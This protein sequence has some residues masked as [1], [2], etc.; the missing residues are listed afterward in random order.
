MTPN[1]AHARVRAVHVADLRRTFSF[2]EAIAGGRRLRFPAVDTCAIPIEGLQR[3]GGAFLRQG[4]AAARPVSNP[5][6]IGQ[7]DVFANGF[8]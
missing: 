7:D 2:E 8:E 4:K 5:C 6:L 1:I 3:G